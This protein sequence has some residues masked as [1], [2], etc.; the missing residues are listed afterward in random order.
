[1]ISNETYPHC[2]LS[3]DVKIPVKS[4]LVKK[5][6][7]KQRDRGMTL[8]EF[9]SRCVRRGEVHELVTT[10][11][12]NLEAGDRVNDVGFIGFVEIHNAG[13]IEK[14]DLVLANE[15]QLGTVVGFDEC[16]FP[17]HYNILIESEQLISATDLNLS[18]LDTFTFINAADK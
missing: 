3:T 16:H 18:L 5:L 13:V 11:Q 4:L 17:N 1:M 7:H 9:E 8:I 6:F 2:D 14:G 12:R 10:T 15:E